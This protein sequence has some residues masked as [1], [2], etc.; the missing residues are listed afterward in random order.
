MSFAA[1]AAEGDTLGAADV[2]G[3]L[4][5]MIATEYVPKV[6]TKFTKPGQEGTDAIRVDVVAL[7]QP[8]QSGQPSIYRD[9][10]WFN[11][12]LRSTLR[13][14]IGTPVLARMGQGTAKPGQDAPFT[15][16]DATQDIQAVQFAEAWM[17]QHPEFEREAAQKIAGGVGLAAPVP[18]GNVALPGVPTVPSQAPAY[19]PSVAPV[20]QA[21]AYAAPQ[22]PSVAPMPAAPAVPAPAA[23]TGAID[24]GSLAAL[25]PEEQAKLLALLQAQAQAQ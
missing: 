9:V 25:P 24:L 4:L 6:I 17:D 8:D 10:L 18:A 14:Q 21:V 20:P 19:A 11:V 5:V 13:K 22:V 7:T 12:G 3:H 1:P 15:L 23:P 2:L 16:V